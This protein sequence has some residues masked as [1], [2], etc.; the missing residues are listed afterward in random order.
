MTR[1]LASRWSRYVTV[2]SRASDPRARTSSKLS[3]VVT[4]PLTPVIRARSTGMR[5]DVPAPFAGSFRKCPH[6][7]DLSALHVE[8]KHVRRVG[9]DLQ[10]ELVEE[11]RLERSHADDE[12]CAEADREQND[13]R[14]VPR[15]RQVQHRVPQRKRRRV[16]ERRDQLHQQP[17]GKDQHAG[18]H[19]EA[20]A[21]DEADPK[22]CGLP[23]RH[24]DER[25]RHEHHRRNTRRVAAAAPSSRR[26]AAGTA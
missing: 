2:Y 6:A 12:E 5:R 1:S 20:D 7:L 21:H 11:A 10:R 14:L 24:R 18:Q 16:R 26:A 23:R 19:G 8:Q 25:G 22:R 9:A 3:S 4:R 17:S 15:P 13:T